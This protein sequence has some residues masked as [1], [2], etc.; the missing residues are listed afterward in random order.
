MDTITEVRT[1][2]QLVLKSLQRVATMHLINLKQNKVLTRPQTD[3]GT[4]LYLVK[5]ENQ[6]PAKS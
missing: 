3:N 1:K 2:Q 5:S 4:N 6:V